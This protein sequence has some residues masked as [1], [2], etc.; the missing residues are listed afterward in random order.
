MN[1]SSRSFVASRPALVLAGTSFGLLL[2]SFVLLGPPTVTTDIQ[3]PGTQPLEVSIFGSAAC[4]PCH[5]GYDAAVEPGTNWKGSMMAQASRDP[6]FW[7]ALAIAEQDFADGGDICLRCHMSIGWTGGR[8]IPTDGSALLDSDADGVTCATCHNLTNPDQSEHLGVQNAP[9]VANDGSEGFYGGGMYVLW[10]GTERL[11]P[12]N[13]AASPHLSL[14]SLFHRSPELCGTCHDVSNPVTGDLAHNNGAQTP[15]APGQFSGIPGG[16][17]ADKA[18]FK[19]PAYKYGIVERTYSEH[20]VSALAT[21]RVFDYPSLP[22]DLQDGALKRAYDQAMASTATGDYADGTTRFFTCQTCHMPPVT[23]KGCN[24][25]GAPLRTDIP[26][27]DQTGG[28]YFAPDAIEYLDGLGRLRLGGGMSVDDTNAMLAGKTRAVRNLQESATLSLAGNTLKV[29]N[30]TGHKLISGYPEGRRMWLNV[31]WYNANNSLL[32]EDGAYGNLSTLINDSPATVRTIQDLADPNLHIY[33][34]EAGITQEWATE[35]IGLGTAG[36]LAV[37]F[38]RLTGATSKTLADVAGQVPGTASHTQH[39]ILNNTLVEDTRIPPYG[40]SYNDAVDRNILPVPDTQYGNPGAGGTY[41]YFDLVNLSPPTNAAYAAIDLLYQPTSWEYIQ[42]LDLANDGSNAFL[43]TVGDDLLEAWQN[44]GMAEPVIMASIFW[45]NSFQAQAFCDAAEL[46]SCPCGNEGDPDSGCDIQQG[47]GGVKLSAL[48]QRTMPLNRA[49]VLGTGYPPN[50][51]P[52]AIVIRG[53]GIDAASP[54]T[55]GDGL[56]C[57]SNPIVRLGASFAVGGAST[58][59]FGHG[60][61]AGSGT[62]Y[63]QLWFRNAPAMFCTPDAF[64]LSNGVQ[65]NWQ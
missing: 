22:A 44:T 29:I 30:H 47:T 36:T 39:F 12:Y 61:V 32:R 46:A 23:G 19:N 7:A 55:F 3:L 15:L 57:V 64:N 21:T 49:T 58:H 27:H 20:K 52:T 37:E 54:V 59:T 11:G 43:A 45:A 4:T 13:D 5:A 53:H 62:F 33:H 40:M 24:S 65:L 31:K 41:D 1:P 16:P 35:L 38:D 17:V 10:N 48:A 6:V 9:F 42:F 8:S 34:V 50:S 26:L 14:Q 63:Y 28:N 51:T 25:G 18:A 56:R 2:T 60:Q